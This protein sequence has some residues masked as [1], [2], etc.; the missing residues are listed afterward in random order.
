M[1][2]KVAPEKLLNV[3]GELGI[4]KG[5]CF[6]TLL[7]FDFTIKCTVSFGCQ[8]GPGVEPS[9][10]S[11]SQERSLPGMLSSLLLVLFGI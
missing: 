4:Q 1:A 11:V 8:S 3:D 2:R 10:K 5:E 7:N 9:I 6:E